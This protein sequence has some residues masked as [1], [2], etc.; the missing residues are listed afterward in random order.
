M[1]PS[2]ILSRSKIITRHPFSVRSRSSTGT[3]VC[4]SRSFVFPPSIARVMVT[5]EKWPGCHV[6]KRHFCTIFA[7]GTCASEGGTPD[8]GHT[9]WPDREA[10]GAMRRACASE[11]ATAWRRV[12]RSA[13]RG[14][15]WFVAQWAARGAN[16][17][18]TS[19][20]S[21]PSTDPLNRRMSPPTVASIDASAAVAARIRFASRSDSYTKLAFSGNVYSTSSL[22]V[23]AALSALEVTYELFARAVGGGLAGS[24]VAAASAAATAAAASAPASSLV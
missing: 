12:P 5:S 18:R 15:P 1:P 21:L 7:P 19:S 13:A 23:S 3:P 8:T 14:A 22:A 6:L 4:T 24:L 2:T 10:Q 11:G 9:R 16:G 17:A 20:T